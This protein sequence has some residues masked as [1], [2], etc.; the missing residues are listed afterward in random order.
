MTDTKRTAE[1]TPILTSLVET[2]EE[3]MQEMEMSARN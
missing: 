2:I 3:T 1:S